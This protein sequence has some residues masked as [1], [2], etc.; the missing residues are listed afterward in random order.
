MKIFLF[1]ESNIETSLSGSLGLINLSSPILQLN[2]LPTILNSKF[3]NI[4]FLH[5][6]GRILLQPLQKPSGQLMRPK[7]DKGEPSRLPA[8]QRFEH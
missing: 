4:R 8:L 1:D 5:E 2:H 3:T 7:L 6:P